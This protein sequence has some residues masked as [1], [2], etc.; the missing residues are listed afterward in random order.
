MARPRFTI[1][2]MTLKLQTCLIRNYFQH[3]EQKPQPLSYVLLDRETAY[4]FIMF[5]LISKEKLLQ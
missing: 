5:A 4:E 3:I 2:L 1:L